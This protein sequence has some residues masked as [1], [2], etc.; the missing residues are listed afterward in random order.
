MLTLS[1]SLVLIVFLIALQGCAGTEDLGSGEPPR[2]VTP[3]EPEPTGT[4]APKGEPVQ[5]GAGRRFDRNNIAEL[6]GNADAF[7]GATLDIVGK[8]FGEVEQVGG[9]VAWQMWGDPKNSEFNITVLFEKPGFSVKDGDYVHVVGTVVGSFEGENLFGG[10]VSAVAVKAE[11]AG[12]VDAMA[13]APP[14]VKTVAP[15]S[16]QTQHGVSITLEK[17]EFAGTETRVFLTVTNGSG[18]EASFYSH[19]AKAQQ[20]SQQFEPETFTEYPELQSDLLP[21][22]RT[23]GV[24]AFPKMA[25]DQ[26][27]RLFFEASSDNYELDFAPYVFQV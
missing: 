15:R 12:V 27:L 1:R 25:P 6:A 19:T 18:A 23:T 8:V 20:G 26:P 13:A 14:A 22:T 21:G 9:Q 2:D 5:P 16:T 11:S 24:M 3:S 17:V 4:G 10:T 7:K